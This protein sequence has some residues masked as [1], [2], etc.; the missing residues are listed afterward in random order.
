[1][2]VYGPSIPSFEPDSSKAIGSR[3]TASLAVVKVRPVTTVAPT[4]GVTWIPVGPASGSKSPLKCR[5]LVVDVVVERQ[6]GRLGAG[7][8][9]IIAPSSCDAIVGDALNDIA[10]HR[11]IGHV[12]GQ[13]HDL[14]SRVR[15]RL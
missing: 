5:N 10:R 8:A 3:S 6:I 11:D 7:P 14:A 13:E 9:E 12:A 4:A 1:M 15:A 2:T